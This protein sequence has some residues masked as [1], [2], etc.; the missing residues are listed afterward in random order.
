MA[1]REA[2]RLIDTE[3]VLGCGTAGAGPL[4]RRLLLRAARRSA[5]RHA[6]AGLGNPPRQNL[7]AD[8]CRPRRRAPA[9]P[10]FR[11][12]RSGA[13]RS[14]ACW[15]SARSPRRISP[16]RCRWPTR[17]SASLERKGFIVVEAGA[18][19]ARSPARALRPPAR[20][21]RRRAQ[22]RP[23]LKLNKPERELRAFLELHPGS[24]NLKE[25][26]DMVQQRQPGGALAGAQR[27]GDAQAG[28]RGHDRRPDPRAAR[29]EP[30]A[31]GRVRADS[32][33]HPGETLP[34]RFCSTASPGRARPRSI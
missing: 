34:A 17:R 26:E 15:K 5:A 10:R 24:H 9:A 29:P 22:S 20:G 12:R 16:K 4:D 13:S 28:N 19:G 3:P 1:A 31:A 7:V 6:A 23:S 25:L 27:H 18:D 11:A 14:C 21:T 30:R 32:R 2:L 33:G 8:R